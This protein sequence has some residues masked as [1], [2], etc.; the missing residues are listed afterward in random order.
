M[1]IFSEPELLTQCSLGPHTDH[2]H[3]G[4]RIS[5]SRDASNPQSLGREWA[6]SK[7]AKIHDDKSHQHVDR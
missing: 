7:S 4:Y 6:R 2:P 3:P 5:L 1:I